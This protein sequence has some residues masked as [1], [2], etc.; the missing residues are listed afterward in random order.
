[1]SDE[2]VTEHSTEP[3]TRSKLPPFKRAGLLT[4]AAPLVALRPSG[5]SDAA[6][7]EPPSTLLFNDVSDDALVCDP[8]DPDCEVA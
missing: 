1:M 3:A 7:N 5:E 2:R 8:N 6:A 4:L